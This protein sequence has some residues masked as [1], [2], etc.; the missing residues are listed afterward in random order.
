MDAK[1]LGTSGYT[2]RM[3][4]IRIPYSTILNATPSD[5]SELDQIPKKQEHMTY[6]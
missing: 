3:G 5:P 2:T 6:I 1:E 4:L